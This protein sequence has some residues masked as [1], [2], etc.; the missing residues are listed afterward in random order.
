MKSLVGILVGDSSGRETLKPAQEVLNELNIP[1]DITVLSD[2]PD[3]LEKLYLY[4]LT[5]GLKGLEVIIVGG[6]NI[7]CPVSALSSITPVPI[8]YVPKSV[9]DNE[10]T[11]FLPNIADRGKIHSILITDPGDAYSAGLWAAQTLAA[12]HESIYHSLQ[13]VKVI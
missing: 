3:P 8:I 11:T 10:E 13:S 6:G 2:Y 1:T 12:K 7:P 4:M 5:A 9:S